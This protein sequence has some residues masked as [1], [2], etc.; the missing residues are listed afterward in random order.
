MSLQRATSIT[1]YGLAFLLIV[2]LTNWVLFSFNLISY[3]DNVRLSKIL[4]LLIIFLQTVP[5][6]I[7]LF[8]LRKNQEKEKNI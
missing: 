6:I 2:S 7:F 3:F 1:L 8:I 5:L 4:Q